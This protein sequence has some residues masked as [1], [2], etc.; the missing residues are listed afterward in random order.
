M[1]ERKAK[2][3]DL[4]SAFKAQRAKKRCKNIS[5]YIYI[6]IYNFKIITHPVP[7]LPAHH[8]LQSGVPHSP[9]KYSKWPHHYLLLV[10]SFQIISPLGEPRHRLHLCSFIKCSMNWGKGRKTKARKAYRASIITHSGSGVWGIEARVGRTEPDSS[11]FS[12]PVPKL[13]GRCA[14][15]VCVN[16]KSAFLLLKNKL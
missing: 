7:L 5:F 8:H 10:S 3:N 16:F 6:Y 12:H 13:Q 11:S 9:E 2:P 4:S 14:V 1:E 15:C